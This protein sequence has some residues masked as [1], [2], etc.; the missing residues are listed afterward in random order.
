MFK[1]Y[2]SEITRV[3]WTSSYLKSPHIDMEA[4]VNDDLLLFLYDEMFDTI[5]MADVLEHIFNPTLLFSEMKRVLK[6]GGKQLL[7]IPF[8]YNLQK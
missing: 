1:D 6:E 3:D 4:D 8:F 2:V 5:L 7:G